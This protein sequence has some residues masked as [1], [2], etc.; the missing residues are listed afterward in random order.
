M[1]LPQ[2]AGLIERS[3]VLGRTTTAQSVTRRKSGE[4][5]SL[6]AGGRGGRL[7]HAN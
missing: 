2:Q 5:T 6:G 1:R 4:G 3:S 7:L